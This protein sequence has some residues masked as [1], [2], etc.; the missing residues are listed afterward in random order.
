MRR[1]RVEIIK[2]VAEV[3]WEQNEEG[4]SLGLGFPNKFN[5]AYYVDDMEILWAAAQ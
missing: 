4:K 5:K 1:G 3:W 2:W